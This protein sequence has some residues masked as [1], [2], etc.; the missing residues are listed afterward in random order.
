MRLFHD[1]RQILQ[2][3]KYSIDILSRNVQIHFP[4]LGRGLAA[5]VNS[6]TQLRPI[7][8]TVFPICP[9]HSTVTRT[10]GT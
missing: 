4:P 6:K 8:L 2:S 3:L 9:Y 7:Y 1:F 5:G 10:S